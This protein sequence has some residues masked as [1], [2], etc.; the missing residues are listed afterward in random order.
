[1][2]YG[3]CKLERS[4]PLPLGAHCESK[5]MRAAS[6]EVSECKPESHYT[7]LIKRRREGGKSAVPK[8]Q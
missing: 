2:Q 5:E 6:E 4:G 8:L 1:M 7:K 3:G